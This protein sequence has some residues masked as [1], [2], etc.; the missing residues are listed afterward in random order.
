MKDVVV[1]ITRHAIP[2]FFGLSNPRELTDADMLNANGRTLEY[3]VIPLYNIP[4]ASAREDGA[5]AVQLML[6]YANPQQF[7]VDDTNHWAQLPRNPT[8]AD[9]AREST[10]PKER[11]VRGRCF[12]MVAPAAYVV[13]KG[14]YDITR[15]M[16]GR[17]LDNALEGDYPVVHW[18]DRFPRQR[19]LLR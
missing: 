14:T 10:K 2:V 9:L 16:V 18:R 6:L 11:P 1:E 15:E 8:G 17:L 4:L 5:D 12:V 3:L 7:T 19:R 13:D